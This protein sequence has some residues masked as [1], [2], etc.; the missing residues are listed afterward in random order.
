MNDRTP[1]PS[2]EPED[3]RIVG[4][5][6]ECRGE[7]YEGEVVYSDSVNQ[8]HEECILDVLEENFGIAD[9]AKYCGYSR[10]VAGA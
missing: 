5:C 9:I 3:P 10:E 2:L 8:F 7:I 4:Y 6:A 1:E